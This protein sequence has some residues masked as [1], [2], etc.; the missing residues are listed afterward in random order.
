MLMIILYYIKYK[1]VKIGQVSIFGIII[2]KH[3]YL[4]I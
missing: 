4:Y 3:V 2:Q 1:T